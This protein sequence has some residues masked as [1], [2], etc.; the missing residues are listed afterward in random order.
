VVHIKAIEKEDFLSLWGLVGWWNGG[1]ATLDGYEDC[2]T[3][4][5]LSQD[6]SL[7]VT[8]SSATEGPS[9]GYP[10]PVLGAINPYLEPFC[11][12]LSPKVDEIFQ[13]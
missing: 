7:A 11:G 2:R 3:E 9:W 8:G 13:N 10:R 5:G 6:R 4:N 1:S 12:H